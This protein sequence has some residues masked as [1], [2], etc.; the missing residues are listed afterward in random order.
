MRAHVSAIDT[1]LI[2]NQEF[3]GKIPEVIQPQKDFKEPEELKHNLSG[4]SLALEANI[5][6]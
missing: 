5:S 3:N 1:A 2:S 4:P 6:C